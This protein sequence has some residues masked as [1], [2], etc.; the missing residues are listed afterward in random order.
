MK[1]AFTTTL[2]VGALVVGSGVAHA[3]TYFGA[4]TACR[5]MTADGAYPEDVTLDPCFDSAEE[6]GRF[7]FPGAGWSSPDTDVDVYTQVGWK[8]RG[9]NGNPVPGE[10]YWGGQVT[11]WG[12]VRGYQ[13]PIY[14]VDEMSGIGIGS[15]YCYY[16]KI[17][18]KDNGVSYGPA[19]SPGDCF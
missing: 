7:F 15:G 17:W 9:A 2:M 14:D 16:T 4:T 3:D 5:G 6:H 8:A 12:D 19:E 10:P 11:F 18:F 1:G 13:T